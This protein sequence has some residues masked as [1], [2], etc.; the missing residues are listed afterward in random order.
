[1]A[2]LRSMLFA[3]GLAGAAALTEVP[4]FNDTA[5]RG[6]ARLAGAAY[7]DD[8]SLE[9]WSCGEKCAYGASSAQVCRGGR[10]SSV[11]KA[12]VTRWEGRC[13]I[14]MQGLD[15]H[16]ALGL[17]DRPPTTYW[18]AVGGYVHGELLDMWTSVGACVRR[19]LEQIG[20]GVRTGMDISVAGHSFGAAAGSIAMV[21]LADDGWGV[22]ELYA[23]GMPRAGDIEFAKVVNAR[24][25][26]GIWRVTNRLDPF[27]AYEA[28]G[29]AHHVGREV[30]H[31]R[32]D[33]PDSGF[34]ACRSEGDEPCTGP[35]IAESVSLVHLRDHY[36]YMGADQSE[37]GCLPDVEEAM[38]RRMQGPP[39]ISIIDPDSTGN[40]R[41]LNWV[42]GVSL[43]AIGLMYLLIYLFHRR[44]LAQQKFEEERS[45]VMAESEQYSVHLVTSLI[46]SLQVDNYRF[47]GLRH[48]HHQVSLEFEE[49]GFKMGSRRFLQGVTGT[50]IA[51]TISAIMGPSGAGKTTFM[52]V[53]CGKANYG[54]PNGTIRI[55]GEKCE[56]TQIKNILGFVPQDDVVHEMLTVREQIYF[57]ARLRNAP[58]TSMRRIDNIVE[59]VLRVMQ[60]VHVQHSIV[61][62]IESKGISGGQRKRVNIGLE[63]AAM[64]TVLFL[65]EPTSGL[66]ATSA[67][68]IVH[69]LKKMTE[70]GMTVVMV[71][72]QPRYSLFTLCDDVLLLGAGGRTAY[73]GPSEGAKAYFEDVG[74]QMPENENAADWLMDVLSGEVKNTRLADF[75]LE[76][77][78]EHWES[79]SSEW[80]EGGV[81]RD[82]LRS[83]G[84][85]RR[86][87]SAD[88]DAVTRQAL[89]EEWRKF[90]FNELG[91]EELAQVLQL[92]TDTVPT[93]V[94]VE[95]LFMRMGG[96]AGGSV[97]ELQFQDFLLGLRG[98]VAMDAGLSAGP[99][100]S[101]SKVMTLLMGT[102][103]QSEDPE[104]WGGQPEV[105][106]RSDRGSGSLSRATN[107]PSAIAASP[108]ESPLAVPLPV[109]SQATC[110]TSWSKG[111]LASDITNV[112]N[113]EPFPW[114]SRKRQ[115]HPGFFTQ[116]FILLHR[117]LISWL[118]MNKQRAI[119]VALVVFSAIVF[120]RISVGKVSIQSP[121]LCP[122]LTGTHL[123][124]AVPLGISCLHVFGSDRP[125]FW[126]EHA[127]GV[128]VLAF[129]M[130]RVTTSLFDVF[131]LAIV[132]S[133]T[134]YLVVDPKANFQAFW[135][136]F[137]VL[138]FNAMAWGFFISTI[139]P[140]HSSTLA[141]AVALLAMCG[142]LSDSISLANNP[143][144]STI[145]QAKVSVFSWSVGVTLLDMV[146]DN[147]GEMGM[148]QPKFVSG[149]ERV[150]ENP[151]GYHWGPLLVMAIMASIIL[152]LSYIG[153]VFS[154][155]THQV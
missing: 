144:Q 9:S 4:G 19:K 115:V 63:L 133:S 94:V 93:K 88:D 49:L 11:A 60:L 72:H 30:V 29:G 136:A 56:L 79:V 119:A 23:F 132:F 27:P 59:D 82:M 53:L 139:V 16:E 87:T 57:S 98:S 123:A 17:L 5:A 44:H 38:S 155:R 153:L 111:S 39:G 12:F 152:L 85:L 141:F 14:S 3:A 129:W 42:Q 131:V 81:R 143:T 61:G 1:M 25:P 97:T 138:S 148:L 35:Y 145:N 68:G 140:P 127:R 124:L 128:N 40:A 21:D 78:F 10:A 22:R 24:F 99:V 106:I 112:S 142:G 69:S 67:L 33:D 75:K 74:F 134:W 101:R 13:V 52:N 2:A 51:G 96:T 66:D 114:G 100:R 154:G 105:A 90:N 122:T 108:P 137:V 89:H 109:G 121:A 37:V 102:P 125:V 15:A 41:R 62:G 130:S 6:Y 77:L 48:I 135:V 76:T 73:L 20:C 117:C 147:D 146:Q 47:R 104:T 120:G 34:C 70:L 71:I 36:R 110:R 43:A 103:R 54:T 91:I 50:F 116:Y 31:C 113:S 83:G 64:P 118:R 58:G 8:D 32:D 84:Q 151:L 150:M 95:E 65:D 86:W 18:H 7:C 45:N 28:A 55:N 26:G 92:C 46:P 149:Y 80:Q 107:D 126:R